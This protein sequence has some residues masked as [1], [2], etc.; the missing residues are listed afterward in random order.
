[1][2]LP[3]FKLGEA[4]SDIKSEFAY[5]NF[6]D[7]T[8]SIAKLAGK[9]VANVGM[10]TVELGVDI[11]KNAP[12]HLGNMAERG[13]KENPT[14][15]EVQRTKLEEI[16]SKGKDFKQERDAKEAQERAAKRKAEDDARF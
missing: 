3:Y 6:I 4:L 11:V 10:L 15:T 2:K 12:A 8:S 16:A 5:G 14:L 7:K 13:L 9:T 1:M